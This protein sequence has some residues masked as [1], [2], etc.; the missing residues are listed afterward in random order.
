[1]EWLTDPTVVGIVALV[2]IALN[3]IALMI[4]SLRD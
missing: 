2:A 3:V 4:R 1:M